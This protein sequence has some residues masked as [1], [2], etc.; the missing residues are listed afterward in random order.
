MCRGGGSSCFFGGKRNDICKKNKHCE[1]TF[2]VHLFSSANWAHADLTGCDVPNIFTNTLRVQL[3]ASSCTYITLIMATSQTGPS[4]RKST[5]AQVFEWC[6][7]KIPQEC[8]TKILFSETCMIYLWKMPRVV[9]RIRNKTHTW[10]KLVIVWI[11]AV[12]AFHNSWLSAVMICRWQNDAIL[13]KIISLLLSIQIAHQWN[14]LS[15]SIENGKGI[16]PGI[17]WPKLCC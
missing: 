13:I 8:Y 7:L 2:L 10:I 4:C 16:S 5:P 11:V 15:I 12:Y 14:S 6:Y 1:V 9:M 3:A 17:E